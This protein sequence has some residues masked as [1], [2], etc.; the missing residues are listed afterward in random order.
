MFNIRERIASQWTLAKKHLMLVLV[1]VGILWAV[2]IVDTLL[3]DS[4]VRLNDFA[5]HPRTPEGLFCILT[6]PFLHVDIHHL[7]GNTIALVILGWI[8][9]MSGKT[10]FLRVF[11]V[12]ALVSGLGA[13]TFGEVS[14]GHEGASGV[15]YG[16]IGYMLAR[17]WFSRRLLWTLIAL[18]V[19]LMHLGQL[20]MLLRND[21]SISWSSHFWGFTG[22]VVLAWWM[23]GRVPVPGPVPPAPSDM[24]RQ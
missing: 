2:F 5:I 23:H 15:L 21:P 24:R 8:L 14:I 20:L 7:M 22:G 18:I 12:T 9:I 4:W 13:W 17:G 3:P 11:L 6:A 19:G 16:M 10:V 1:F